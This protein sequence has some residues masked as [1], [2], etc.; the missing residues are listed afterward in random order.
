MKSIYMR[1]AGSSDRMRE[2]EIY[3]GKSGFSMI[4]R[5]KF[6]YI[7]TWEDLREVLGKDYTG[8]TRHDT[9]NSTNH[10][11]NRRAH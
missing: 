2:Y 6:K 1:P 7:G 8:Y 9:R 4:Y 5:G 11:G 10:G 3:Y